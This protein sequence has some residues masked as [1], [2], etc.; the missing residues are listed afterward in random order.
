MKSQLAIVRHG[1]SAYNLENKFT[2]FAD[3]DLTAQGREEA[4]MCGRKLQKMHFD[5]CFTSVLKR[6]IETLHI[7]LET[8]GQ[9][10]L[11]VF[12]DAAL[13]ERN[14][15]D[16]QGLNKAETA[17]KYGSDKVA[18]WRRSFDVAPPGGESLKQTQDRVLP[19]Y[20]AHI[21]P[22]LQQGK[23]VLVVAHG[24]SLRALMMHLENIS[25]EAIAHIELL[26]GVPRVYDFDDNGKISYVEHLAQ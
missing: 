5:D 10:Q 1:Q 25:P 3:V 14:Y 21:E 24:N 16:L 15:G 8:T 12:K 9:T 18:L 11:P 17:E 23:N 19:Y 22:L 2:G 4:V 7:I 6:A 20:Y 13:N 26:T